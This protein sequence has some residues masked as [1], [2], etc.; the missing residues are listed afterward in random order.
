MHQCQAAQCSHE[1]ERC[2]KSRS[3]MR[4]EVGEVFGHWT[5]IGGDSRRSSAHGKP[6]VHWLC[7]CI[8]GTERPV[9]SYALR[10]GKSVSCG[11]VT[12]KVL[13]EQPRGSR[14]GAIRQS[15]DITGQRFGRLVV[16][17]R[18]RS[19][20]TGWLVRCDC[21]KERFVQSTP[22]KTGHTKA[23]GCLNT[24]HGY[25]RDLSRSRNSDAEQRRLYWVWASMRARCE[26]PSDRSFSSYGARGIRV[27]ARWASFES[28]LEDMGSR[29]SPSHQLDRIDN[30]GNYEPSNCR[31]VSVTQQQ[32][33]KRNSRLLA[34]AG[35]TRTQAE[36]SE[37][38]GIPQQLIYQRIKRGW[39]LDQALGLTERAAAVQ[40][41]NAE[42]VV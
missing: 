15:E 5:V 26:R 23:C 3:F 30:D 13:Q 6:V 18:A 7:R 16:L 29:P 41:I 42:E 35:V 8:C 12:R 2:L 22:I 4:L 27:C 10:G 37:T 1:R 25:T 28:F 36:W 40:V 38:T 24:T 19:G 11:C 34:L 17:R 9:P 39:S 14:A 32:R 21:G 33:N 31:W 20:E